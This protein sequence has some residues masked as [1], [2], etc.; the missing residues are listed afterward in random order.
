M[1]EKRQNLESRTKENRA[2]KPGDPDLTKQEAE[3]WYKIW[4][5]EGKPD[6][7]GHRTTNNM[8]PVVPLPFTPYVPPFPI[9][10]PGEGGV[11][12]FDF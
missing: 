10:S 3:E 5:Q 8:V 7:E 12:I 1:N 2:L 11:F 4:V 9:P 6:A